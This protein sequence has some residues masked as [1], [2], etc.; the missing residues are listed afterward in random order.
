MRLPQHRIR[1]PKRIVSYPAGHPLGRH[2]QSSNHDDDPYTDSFNDDYIVG[3][4]GWSSHTT[5]RKRKRSLLQDRREQMQDHFRIRQAEKIQS[6]AAGNNR[7]WTVTG[8]YLVN[9]N[10]ELVEDESLLVDA[11]KDVNET[12]TLT[13][14][15]DTE[16][17]DSNSEGGSD[18]IDE[19]STD[20]Q[21]TLNDFETSQNAERLA[22]SSAALDTAAA[23]ADSAV[24]IT[25]TASAS[26]E[27]DSKSTY[28]PIRL[29]AILTDDESSGSKYLTE[30][31]KKILMEDMINP[32]L[33]AW[34]KALHVVPVKGSLV[35]DKT[36]LFDG[37]SCGPGL[38][39][40][41]LLYY[42]FSCSCYRTHDANAFL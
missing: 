15:I 32:A 22:E 17:K 20:G 18:P 3:G 33:Y 30:S 6:A 13:A 25:D 36:Q 21:I 2:L 19:E 7:Y 39:R 1:T 23:A 8:R 40:E 10:N 27:D 11:L 34:S 24:S 16:V 41:S 29:R 37:E 42:T 5:G 9:E 28:Q 4:D 31:Q 26:A 14:S 38:V 12:A 35:V